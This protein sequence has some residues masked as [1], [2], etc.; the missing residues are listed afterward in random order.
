MVLVV[1]DEL[2]R[3]HAY[4]PMMKQSPEQEGRIEQCYKTTASIKSQLN[5]ENLVQIA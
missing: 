5:K 2:N 3:Q 4:I 1:F